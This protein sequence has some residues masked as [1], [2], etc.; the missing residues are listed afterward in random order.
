MSGIIDN[1]LAEPALGMT[2][3]GRAIS[4]SSMPV[5]IANLKAGCRQSHNP[6]SSPAHFLE[7]SA[8]AVR[9][10]D[11]AAG[12]GDTASFLPSRASV[13]KIIDDLGWLVCS[14]E[15]KEKLFR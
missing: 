5:R 10:D 3:A 15:N 6:V 13:E 12:T 11:D 14:G 4:V 1:W 9:I 8:A 7:T 2:R